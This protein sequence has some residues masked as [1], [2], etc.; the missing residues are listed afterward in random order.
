M[1]RV[2]FGDEGGVDSVGDEGE[3]EVDMREEEGMIEEMTEIIDAKGMVVGV[4]ITAEMTDMGESMTIE[5]VREI[6]MIEEAKEIEMKEGP[7]E[8]EM[9]EEKEMTDVIE[10]TID[11]IEIMVDGNEMKEMTDKREFI[12]MIAIGKEK[13]TETNMMIAIGMTTIANT[14]GDESVLMVGTNDVIIV[15]TMIAE[16]VIETTRGGGITMIV[17]EIMIADEIMKEDD[18]MTKDVLVEIERIKMMKQHER[19]VMMTRKTRIRPVS[20]VPVV[21]DLDLHPYP[22][23]PQFLPL[24]VVTIDI[25]LHLQLH[26]VADPVPH[27]LLEEENLIAISLLTVPP[28]H[29]SPA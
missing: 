11:V 24:L 15:T 10:I 13:T 26:L 2:R 22:Q 3:E 20:L 14:S 1:K 27:H 18:T 8:I 6:E 9:I 28:K 19:I 25:V 21:D 23:H 7:G 29:L 4:G 17:E 16:E 5:E 12:T